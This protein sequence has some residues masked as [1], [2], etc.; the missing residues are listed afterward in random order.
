M[1]VRQGYALQANRS[2]RALRDGNWSSDA[3]GRCW[4]LRRGASL[5]HRDHQDIGIRCWTPCGCFW[6]SV[7]LVCTTFYTQGKVFFPS[8]LYNVVI[9]IFGTQPQIDE[10]FPRWCDRSQLYNGCSL[11]LPPANNTPPGS[12]EAH[13]SLIHTYWWLFKKNIFDLLQ[14]MSFV[15]RRCKQDRTTGNLGRS[16]GIF[17]MCQIVA[18]WRPKMYRLC[19]CACYCCCWIKVMSGLVGTPSTSGC[20]TIAFHSY[21]ALLPPKKTRVVPLS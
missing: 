8:Q 6:Q 1:W 18:C 19:C 2:S 7:S 20:L 13:E 11:H 16:M 5:Q 14:N 10:V 17:R 21:L 3:R 12:H 4:N 15:W 9:W